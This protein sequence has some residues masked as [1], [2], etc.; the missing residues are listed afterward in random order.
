MSQKSAGVRLSMYDPGGMR[1]FVDKGIGVV[2]PIVD[3]VELD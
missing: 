1:Q 3:P 2:E